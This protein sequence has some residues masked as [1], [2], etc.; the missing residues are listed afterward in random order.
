VTCA[1]GGKHF[2][3]LHQAA[4]A[5]RPRLSSRS[6][7]RLRALDDA[8]ALLRHI[9]PQS[10]DGFL[11]DLRVELGLA[12]EDQRGDEGNIK[13]GDSA[14]SQE[15]TDM[16][17]STDID[18]DKDR[19]ALLG[20]GTSSSAGV[21]AAKVP[22]EGTAPVFSCVGHAGGDGPSQVQAGADAAPVAADA[23][24]GGAPPSRRTLARSLSVHE[25]R[26]SQ[27]DRSRL[28][29]GLARSHRGK[30]G[31]HNVTLPAGTPAGVADATAMLVAAITDAVAQKF[32][33][34]F[35]SGVLD[36]RGSYRAAGCD[37]PLAGAADGGKRDT[38]GNDNKKR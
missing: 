24:V 16:N 3:G 4:R 17:A 14:A 26:C 15:N 27:A 22:F 9:S 5:L 25:S 23:P 38:G 33:D 35:A 32:A 36:S 11:A 30:T 28:L 20:G 6:L 7:R 19:I 21:P 31:V 29:G 37:P 34:A 8:A 12:D 2:Q 1:A 10:V 13:G 18:N